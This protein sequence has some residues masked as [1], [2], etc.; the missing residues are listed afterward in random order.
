MQKTVSVTSTDKVGVGIVTEPR[1]FL[2]S[3][4]ALYVSVS[5]FQRAYRQSRASP[6]AL[7]SDVVVIKLSDGVGC[8]Q[9]ADESF[10]CRCPEPPHAG[11]FCGYMA[12]PP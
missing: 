7:T 10:F 3:L 1:I 4:F 12:L 11:H 5:L 9:T 2:L 8:D 6:G